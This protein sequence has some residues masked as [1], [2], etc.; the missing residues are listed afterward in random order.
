M[1]SNGRHGRYKTGYYIF[2]QSTRE[3]RLID[4]RSISSFMRDVYMNRCLLFFVLVLMLISCSPV[5]P[6]VPNDAETPLPTFTPSPVPPTPTFTAEELLKAHPEIVAADE[7]GMPEEQAKK[8]EGMDVSFARVTENVDGVLV[9]SNKTGA[10]AFYFDLQTEFLVAIDRWPVITEVSRIRENQ[11]TKEELFSNEYFAWLKYLA[12]KL[13]FDPEKIN[14]D[15]PMGFV[16]AMSFE[17]MTPSP[18]TGPNFSD[19][20]T[21]PFKR[22]EALGY[23]KVPGP[24]TDYSILPNFHIVEEEGGWRV[25]PIIT[26]T[27]S[28]EDHTDENLK[29]WEDG[30]NVTPLVVSH[31]VEAYPTSYPNKL[32]EKTYTGY[33]REMVEAG[34]EA[35]QNGD[36]SQLSKPGM[37]LDTWIPNPVDSWYQ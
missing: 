28:T 22:D 2:S 37:V 21:A 30:M 18:L 34:Y 36:P 27:W 24:V 7:F 10:D 5:Q 33:G 15:V 31:P 4:I 13:E 14:T 6:S 19:P 12:S 8:L 1:N 25:Y 23:L 9:T 32:V 11:M 29:R 16:G 17:I 3:I 35:L 20:A 26:T